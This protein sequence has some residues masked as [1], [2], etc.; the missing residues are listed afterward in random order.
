MLNQNKI[1]T[2]VEEKAYNIIEAVAENMIVEHNSPNA[3]PVFHAYLHASCSEPFLKL[4]NT[5]VAASLSS[6]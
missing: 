6:S 2:V 4:N 1:K 3:F 5:N